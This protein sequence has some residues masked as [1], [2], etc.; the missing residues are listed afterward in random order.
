MPSPPSPNGAR[1]K[2]VRGSRSRTAHPSHPTAEHARLAEEA[3]RKS[4][5][6]RW[7]PYLPER[8][9]GTVREDYSENGDAWNSFPHAHASQRVYRWGE[10]GLLGIC[11]R[12]CRLCFAIALWNEKD[13]CLKER[14]FGLTNPEGNHG[15]DAKE[16]WY[17]LDSTPTHSYSKALY[18][19]PQRAFPYQA[20]LEAN[21]SRGKHECE[22][23]LDDTGIFEDHR[24]FDVFVEYAKAAPE[25]LL[26]RITIENRGPDSAPLHVLPTLWFRNTWSWGAVHGAT[27][28]RPHLA[29]FDE[30]L[31]LAEHETL[32]RYHFHFQEDAPLLFTENETN[33]DALYGHPIPG[34]FAKDG[35]GR[36]VVHGHTEAVRHAFGTKVAPHYRLQIPPGGRRILRLR[37]CEESALPPEQDAFEA[38]DALL[39]LR[40]Q[41]CDA[42]YR[43]VTSPNLNDDQKLVVRQA[44]A[45]LLWSKQYYQLVVPE[46]LRGDATQPPPPPAHA[47]LR[48]GDWSHLYASDVLSMPDKWEYPWFAAWDLSFHMIP[49]ARIDPVFAK[50]QLELLLREWYMHPSGQIPAYEWN[51]NDVNPP[52]HAWACWRVYKISA[53]AGE[54]DTLFL[55]RCF[56]K[57]LLNFTWWVNRKDVKGRHIFAGGFLGLDNIGL[58]DRSR[59]LPSGHSLAQADGTAWMAFYCG[60]ML[61]M[62]LELAQQRPAYEDI[63]SKFFEHFVQIIDAMNDLGAEGLW[64]EEDGFYYDE[65]LIDGQ[66]TLPLRTRSMV[67][68][69]PLL[70]VEVLDQAEINHLPGFKS[71]LEWF[72]KNRPGLSRHVSSVVKLSDDGQQIAR[73]LAIPSREQLR[74]VLYYVLH[75][76]EFLSPWGIR[77]LS[78][79]HDQ[80]P[81]RVHLN[82]EEYAIHY[83]PGESRSGLFGGNSNWRGP[84]WFPVNYL[85][86]EALERYHHFYGDD[87]QVQFPSDS[88]NWVNLETVS[89]EI[90]RRLS[91]IFTLDE[92]GN[93]PCFGENHR[94][95][96]DP[97]WRDY[98]L[99]HEYFHGDLGCGLGASHQTGWTALIT[100]CLG[101]VGKIAES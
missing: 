76:D 56:Q 48:N 70:A 85:L 8:Q 46:W 26:I 24:Y 3:S 47:S 52:V 27:S 63:A 41:E 38:F 49:M 65:L 14:L 42:F 54:R 69:I 71:R 101:I 80:H 45:G 79:V 91:S 44:Y 37:L 4:N 39:E 66:G 92:R 29:H 73:L 36:A 34:G 62:A 9:W 59:P 94:Y 28:Q 15:E 74:R 75:P 68:I 90:A 11:D 32:G 13:P 20:L 61:S 1:T 16:A 25:D 51:F 35:I 43:C 86:I 87:F 82:G 97:H 60:T 98:V 18:K 5:W 22:F 99:F 100:R 96:N 2:P 53:Q 89:R 81:C 95:A 72:L 30:R 78:R 12:Q 67:G 50:G 7:G 31:V 33:T 21:R 84:I 58:F 57:L 6:R 77:S 88:G 17:Y 23:E 19:Y 64:N 10:D 83:E 40:R 93:R 55:E